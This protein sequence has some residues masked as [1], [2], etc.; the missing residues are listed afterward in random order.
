[1]AGNAAVC[2]V[3]SAHR[4]ALFQRLQDRGLDIP[5][6]IQE[7]RYIAVDVHEALDAIIMKNG[8]PDEAQFLKVWTDLIQSVA[9]PRKG[10]RSRTSVFGECGDLLVSEGN[11]VG[12]LQ[13]EKLRNR[14]LATHDLD[15]LCG[16]SLHTIT[17]SSNQN[18]VQRICEEH[19]AAYF[20]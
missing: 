14:L 1:V 11:L 20:R 15:I 13:F 3:T 8:M 7:Q 4:P 18:N 12:L 10:T 16:Y 9:A 5:F 17:A 6:A 19:S 2:V